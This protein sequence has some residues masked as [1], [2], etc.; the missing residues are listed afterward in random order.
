MRTLSTVIGDLVILYGYIDRENET[1]VNVCAKLPNQGY[2]GLRLHVI[3]WKL[4]PDKQT[5]LMRYKTRP[6]DDWA[7]IYDTTFRMTEEVSKLAR[8][9]RSKNWKLD[10]YENVWRNTKTGKRVYV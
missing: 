6:D 9:N 1:R 2:N 5:V 3:D 4:D 8:P 7:P 10:E